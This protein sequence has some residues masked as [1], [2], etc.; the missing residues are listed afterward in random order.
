VGRQFS[1]GNGFPRKGS[2]SIAHRQARQNNLV[3]TAP[4]VKAATSFLIFVLCVISIPTA[5]ASFLE[6]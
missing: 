4:P 2:T 3:T 5:P 6:N 1:D